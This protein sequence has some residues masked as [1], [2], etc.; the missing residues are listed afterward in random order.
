MVK[1]KEYSAPEVRQL[2]EYSG[3][4]RQLLRRLAELQEVERRNLA[5]SLHDLIGQNLTALG[6]GLD[7]VRAELP[8]RG[9]AL[10]ERLNDMSRLLE[11]TVGSIRDV[12]AELRPPALDD[13]GLSPALHAYA[14]Q[15]QARTG[16]RTSVVGAL[17]GDLLPRDH[18]LAILRVV[19]EALANAARHSGATAMTIAVSHTGQNVR[20]T[21]EDNGRG[22]AEPLG[23]RALMRGGWGLPLMRERTE[24]IGG[25]LRLESLETGTRVVMDVPVP[26]A[27]PGHPD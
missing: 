14:Q 7:I 6:I 18:M 10:T 25:A 19:Q 9:G 22:L 23:A 8:P 21:V 2:K 15:F 1:L 13:Y 24:S 5:V 26:Y 27:D 3:R 20:I 17:P 11:Q 12:I 4:I 16:L